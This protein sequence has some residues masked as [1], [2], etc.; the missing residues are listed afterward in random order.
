MNNSSIKNVQCRKTGFSTDKF[1][2]ET[3]ADKSKFLNQKVFCK[4]SW[5]NFK[6][7]IRFPIA[8]T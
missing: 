1:T 8:K 2:L 6:Y 5:L 4:S 7:E 3:V